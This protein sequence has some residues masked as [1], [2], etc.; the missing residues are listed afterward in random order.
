MRIA[1]GPLALAAV[2]MAPCARAEGIV[3]KITRDGR[4]LIDTP[5]LN[6][7]P[8]GKPY[9][10]FIESPYLICTQGTDPKSAYATGAT[11]VDGASAA[12]LSVDKKHALLE[13]KVAT[14]DIAALKQAVD[15]CSAS[16]V[17]VE[18]VHK[19]IEIPLTNGTYTAKITKSITVSVKAL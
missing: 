2:M 4:V 12:L 11:A 14:L 6:A 18:I 16:P 13:I 7:D 1:I 3:V 10:N 15:K 8:V 19:K 17:P 9:K 5:I